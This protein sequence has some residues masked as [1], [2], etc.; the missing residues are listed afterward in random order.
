MK[1]NREVSKR[2]WLMGA[3]LCGLG[4]SCLFL[5]ASKAGAAGRTTPGENDK[6]IVIDGSSTSYYDSLDGAIRDCAG[7]KNVIIRL[8]TD[9]SVSSCWHISGNMNGVTLDLCGYSLT[10]TNAHFS[11]DGAV[12]R[13]ESGADFRIINSRPD[14]DNTRVHM[15][16]GGITG[17]HSGNCGGG[18][19]I[20]SGGKLKMDDVNVFKN[21]TDYHGGGVY[22]ED[23]GQLDMNRGCFKENKSYDAWT[24][25]HGGAIYNKGRIGLSGVRFEGNYSENHGG[26]IY[27]AGGKMVLSSCTFL[28]NKAKNCGGAI[29]IDSENVELYDCIVERNFASDDGGGIWVNDHKVFLAGGRIRF[30]LADY[31]GG[32]YVDSRYDIGIQGKLVIDGNS[33]TSSRPSNLVLQEG[34]VSHAEAFDGGLLP[35]SRIG[36]GKTKSLSSGGIRSVVNTTDYEINAGYF[37]ADDG[38]VR[39]KN[40]KEKKEVF[41]ATAFDE[42][43]WGVLLFI[44][45]E[46]IGGVFA[47]RML[48]RQLAKK[49]RN[50]TGGSGV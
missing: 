42:Y 19:H 4:F 43:G 33:T 8:A 32:V 27:H 49:K 2:I 9:A 3:L 5:S 28:N 1:K 37:F 12:L 39:L 44:V 14:F 41:L 34:V 11:K 36:I 22:I 16:G 45:L 18:I 20:C 7:K 50:R 46:V 25:D 21:N 6:A 23:G 13:I 38:R 35:G 17:G 30:N 31:G 48:K 26:A 24:K 29:A 15:K 47:I 10:R 40:E